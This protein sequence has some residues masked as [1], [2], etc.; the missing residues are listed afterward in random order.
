MV[1][2]SPNKPQYKAN[3]HSHT[4]RSDGKMTAEEMKEAYRKAGYQILSVTDHESPKCYPDLT[5]PDFLML[6]GYEIYIRPDPLCRGNVYGPEVHLNLFAKDP[7]NE[8]IICYNESS[9]KYCTPAERAALSKAGSQRQREYTTEYVNEVIRTARENGY[10]VAYNHPVWSMETQERILS[11]EGCFSL[12]I[13]NGGCWMETGMEYNGELYQKLLLSGKRM[14]VHAADDN[15]NLHPLDSPESDS[16]VAWTMILADK[17]DYDSVFHALETGEMYASMGPVIKEVS[18]DGGMIHVECS[19]AET[20][21]VHVGSK[22]PAIIHA[23]QGGALTSA[24]LRLPNGARYAQISVTDFRG[25]HADTRG[26]FR[27]ELGL[28][29]L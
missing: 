9:T 22:A 17:L 4:T 20:I 11:Y 16:F 5:E 1:L 21:A 24:D 19:E 18:F 10:L 3:L 7:L 6:T 25:R 13:M 14:F 23:P 27:D 15:H 8:T 26:Y 12:E 2:I 28:P 29:P